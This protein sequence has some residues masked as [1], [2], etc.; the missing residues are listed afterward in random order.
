MRNLLLVNFF[1]IPELIL[2]YSK[3]LHH[4]SIIQNIIIPVKILKDNLDNSSE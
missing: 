4:I 1:N 3:Y 2:Y